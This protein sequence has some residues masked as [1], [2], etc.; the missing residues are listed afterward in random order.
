MFVGCF[1]EIVT[2]W[3]FLANF[4]VCGMFLANG[5]R[6]ELRIFYLKRE[7]KVNDRRRPLAAIMVNVHCASIDISVGIIISVVLFLTLFFGFALYCM[8]E[9]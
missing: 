7:N 8:Y 9:L 3:V 4:D 6:M 2:G 1:L 5:K